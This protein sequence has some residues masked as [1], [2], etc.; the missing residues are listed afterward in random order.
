MKLV[1]L[2]AMLADGLAGSP[3][4]NHSYFAGGCVRDYLLDP[5]SHPH[6][7]DIAVE[8]ENGGALLAEEI[9]QRL[10][11]SVPVVY[12]T[13]GTASLVLDGVRMEFVQT[14]RESYRIKDRKPE[15]SFGSLME[16]AM[17]RDFGINALYMRIADGQI[18]DLSGKGI[19][20]VEAGVISCVDDPRRVFRE[21]PLRLLRA[22][23]FSVRFGF[24]IEDTSLAS[25][26][27]DAGWIEHISEERI[28]EEVNQ[29][30]CCPEG[31]KAAKA[32]MVLQQT[33]I[34]AYIL[35]ELSRLDGL[36]QNKYHHLDAFEHTL[37]VIRN[38]EPG[39]IA[40]WA[41]LLHDIG[42]AGTISF[43][44]DGT[45]RFIGHERLSSK[46]AH[47]ILKSYQIAKP[48]RQIIQRVIAGHMRF[49]NSGE[50]GS[51]MKP[52]TLLR[53]ADQYGAALWQL[54]DLVHAD[55]L[56]HAP[57]Y[58][59]PEQVPGLRRRFLDLQDRIPR[60]CLT[61]KDLI[62]TFGIAPGPLLGSLLQAAKEAWYQDPEMGREELLDYIDKQLLQER[63]TD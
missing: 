49:K 58:R 53:I 41:A 5:D 24:E 46:L 57:Q 17:R 54:L 42:K 18:L 1:D 3:L 13:F 30:L 40:R 10:G 33:G 48:Q 21:D 39:C 23:R 19:K 61:G 43:K 32:M 44:S 59:H 15:V 9:H 37:E 62:D 20:D 14:R 63:K 52:E 26:I 2:R 50:D 47:S 38:S 4:V 7:V 8:V 16:D 31:K 6:D 36:K 11:G 45:P 51:L 56:A 34:L 12:H 22:I 55:N 60:F 28:A 29:M 25:L 27:E 35:P